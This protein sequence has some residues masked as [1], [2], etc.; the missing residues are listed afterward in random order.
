M[1]RLENIKQAGFFA[2][3][4]ELPPIIASYIAPSQQGGRLI[5]PCA[6]KGVALVELAKQ[7]NLDPYGVEL[8]DERAA[9]A[10]RH[11]NGYLLNRAFAENGRSAPV[12]TRKQIISG[13]FRSLRTTPG[14]YSVNYNNPPYMFAE[15]KEDGRT[16]YQ[17]LRDTR[18]YLQTDGI[19]HLGRAA[20][21][22]AAQESPRLSL[23]L[24]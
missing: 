7:L 1:T 2:L 19:P 3:P 17:F 11:V 16:E 14:A 8:N 21:Y 15:E 10:Q 12:E 9:A 5:D 4:Q 6:G 13:N 23:L 18:H 20:A 24:V 22:A